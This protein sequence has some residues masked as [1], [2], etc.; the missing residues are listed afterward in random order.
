MAPIEF[1]RRLPV[2]CIEDVCLMDSFPL[3][4]W[5]MIAD[6]DYGKLTNHDIDTLLCIVVSLCETKSFF[7][8]VPNQSPPVTAFTLEMLQFCPNADA[9]LSSHFRSEYGGLKGDMQML[10][11]A[12]NYYRLRPA[13]VLK[14]EFDKINYDLVEREIEI[15]VEAID[16]HPFPQMLTMLSKMVASRQGHHQGIYLVCRVWL[17]CA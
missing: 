12:I 1:L 6:K 2:I 9:L 10:R 15:L 4:V 14:T 16:F 11:V 13:E 3:I 5:F 7:P 8:Y 17:Q